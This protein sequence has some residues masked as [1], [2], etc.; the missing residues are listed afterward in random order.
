ME[1]ARTSDEHIEVASL[2]G[3]IEILADALA[4]RGLKALVEASLVL[5]RGVA[6]A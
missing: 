5:D 3:G 2:L 6:S 4:R 1:L